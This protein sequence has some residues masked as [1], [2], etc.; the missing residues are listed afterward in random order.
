MRQSAVILTL[1]W[2]LAPLQFLTAVIVARAV[3][4]EGKGAL[5]LLTGL[6]AILV[7][8]VGLGLPSGAAVLCGR[9][10]DR[11]SEVIGTAMAVTGACSLLL[12]SSYAWG[13]AWIL[14]G[15]LSDRELANLQP[16]WIALALAAVAPAALSA[17]AD[18]VLITANAMRVYALRTAASGV[19]ALAVTWILTFHFD[20]GV[21]GALAGYPAGAIVGLAVFASW[22]CSERDLRPPRVRIGCARELL[23]VGLQQHAIGIIALMAKRIDVF[24]IAS[25][26]TLED[27][28]FYAAGI[29]I[30]LAIVSIPRATMWPLVSSMSGRADSAGVPEAVARVSRLQV[31]L[32]TLIAVALFVTAPF[33]V[34]MLF[35]DAFAASV[36]PLRWALLGV[37]LTPITISVNA[38]LT[39]RGQ[40]GR[41]ILSAAVGTAIQLALTILLIPTWGTSA[42][43]AALSANFITTAAIQL[44]IARSS[45]IRVDAMVI[46]RRQDLVELRE[47]LRTRLG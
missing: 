33:I 31:L 39:A 38:I 19:L 27:A 4:P 47:V 8:L 15:M 3:G 12:L 42:G 28:G 46:P 29:V 36:A 40:P 37:P 23:R 24:L 26:L 1:G 44:L 43:A 35:G 20:W 7:S 14:A 45:G 17:V 13:G 41:S 2:F 21:A 5:A 6:T 25:M 10:P 32:M 9:E 18:V 22:W 30:P 16:L 34:R 11:R